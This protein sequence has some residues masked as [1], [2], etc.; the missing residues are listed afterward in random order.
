MA[1]TGIFRLWV[2][3]SVC[4]IAGATR[5]LW[6][7]LRLEDCSGTGIA[8]AICSLEARDELF[9]AGHLEAFGWVVLPP[10]AAFA[11]GVALLWVLRGFRGA[12][13]K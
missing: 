5:F 7:D 11:I 13:A 6:N 9:S 2:V 8:P 10:I 1:S 12:K 3:I 4:W